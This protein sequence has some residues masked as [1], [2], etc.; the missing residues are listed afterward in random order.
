[1]NTVILTKIAKHTLIGSLS[2]YL[3]FA[4]KNN[5]SVRLFF[6]YTVAGIIAVFVV[7]AMWEA[8]DY[9]TAQNP[10]EDN[11]STIVSGLTNTKRET[12]KYMLPAIVRLEIVV[13]FVVI[14]VCALIGAI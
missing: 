7:A 14:I 10:T 8:R 5:P 11:L 3:S 1:M 6:I 13:C 9:L 2:A 4:G 12:R